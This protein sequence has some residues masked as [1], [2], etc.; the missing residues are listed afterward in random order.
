[1]APAL[2]LDP[3]D[4]GEDDFLELSGLLFGAKDRFRSVRATISHAVDGAVA[5]E[6]NRRFVDW[7]FAQGN[8]GMGIIGKPGRA[9]ADTDSG[10]ASTR[11]RVVSGE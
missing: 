11:F 3:V 7:R 10:S 6:A 4:P 8:P 5:E 2:Y 1:M 9:A